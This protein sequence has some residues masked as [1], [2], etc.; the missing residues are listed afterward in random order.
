MN[1]NNLKLRSR[2]LLTV[3]GAIGAVLFLCMVAM[4]VMVSS[5]VFN[6]SKENAR[7]L[8]SDVSADVLR[9]LEMPMNTARTMA[10]TFSGYQKLSPAERRSK[11]DWVLTSVVDKNS[12]FLGT[13]TV[14]E[15]NAL[16][17][18][19]KECRNNLGTDSSGRFIPYWNRGSGQITLEANRDYEVE[20]IGDYYQIPKKTHRESV[21]NP[22]H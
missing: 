13:W 1:W 10:Q 21:I 6:L 8:A 11:F 9:Q 19:D 3:L 12:E 18:R 7:N 2:I 20:G 14:W 16:D 5:V 22:Y 17:G 4:N 15:P